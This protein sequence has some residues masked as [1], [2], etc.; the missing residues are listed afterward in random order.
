MRGKGLNWMF[1][2]W[3]LR[4]QD[5][6]LR[7]WEYQVSVVL[8]FPL[9]IPSRWFS[10]GQKELGIPSQPIYKKKHMHVTDQCK[11]VAS[12][13]SHQRSSSQATVLQSSSH[14]QDLPRHIAMPASHNQPIEHSWW[15]YKK[16]HHKEQIKWYCR[17][18]PAN[19]KL[20]QVHPVKESSRGEICINA[21]NNAKK[22]M[23][24]ME[25]LRLVAN[26][27]VSIFA[28]HK[29]SKDGRQNTTQLQ[30]ILA[31]KKGN[32]C[33]SDC[34]S[35]LRQI[36]IGESWNN[37]GSVMTSSDSK[38][39]PANWD[40]LH[41]GIW[42]YETIGCQRHPS[43]DQHTK[44][45]GPVKPGTVLTMLE[46]FHLSNF[47]QDTCPNQSAQYS[48]RSATH[49]QAYKAEDYVCASF[50]SWWLYQR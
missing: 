23:H 47:V 27:W 28:N 2:E 49:R 20:L 33:N 41:K 30:L 5:I 13:Q 44:W 11:R 48:K 37:C 10:C 42:V 36:C 32:I 6:A 26:K 4:S 1:M 45:H 3:Y 34:Q 31:S 46:D 18:I 22:C 16:T 9:G 19:A 43:L 25:L 21:W 17:R 24:L 12:H 15:M 7:S 50:F 29:G 35:H 39:L 40:C 14:E 8:S 38:V